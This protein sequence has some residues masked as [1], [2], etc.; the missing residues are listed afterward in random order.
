[1]GGLR[2][3]GSVIGV[4]LLTRH[5]TGDR[6][7]GQWRGQPPSRSA[8]MGH[9]PTL[10]R[11]HPDLPPP[12][13]APLAKLGKQHPD[14][15]VETSTLSSVPPPDIT[16][17]LALASSD[18]GALSALQLE[19]I[20]Y[21]CQVIPGSPSRSA[22][23]VGVVLVP[24]L[25]LPHAD[26]RLLPHPRSNTRSSSPVGSARA[27]LSAMARVWARAARWPASSW[28][29]TCGAERRPCGELSLPG[30][31]AGRQVGRGFLKPAGPHPQVQR[32]QRSQV[33]RGAR[34]AG[35]RRPWHR[36]ARTEQG[37]WP[38]APRLVGVGF[39][40]RG[41][42]GVAM[43]RRAPMPGPLPRSSTATTLPQRASSSPPTPP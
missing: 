43:P 31:R 26:P 16:Y 25:T 30:R 19:A 2:R 10:S 5:K 18:S 13:H 24:T 35:H 40:E 11:P 12:H 4:V 39:L 15:V 22:S 33:R 37:G 6:R 21:A 9:A 8:P 42:T 34:P 28:R 17:T 3:G 29:T 23:G 20:T 1:M 32:L 27:S 41:S 14:R 36:G 38:A 7:R